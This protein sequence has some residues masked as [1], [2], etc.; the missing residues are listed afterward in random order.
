MGDGTTAANQSDSPTGRG[1]DQPTT[2]APETPATEEFQWTGYQRDQHNTGVNSAHEGFDSLSLEWEYAADSRVIAPVA[3][4]GDVIIGTRTGTVR[5]LDATDGTE[6]WSTT[7]DGHVVG[8]ASLSDTGVLAGTQK[9][10]VY[11]LDRS[12]GEVTWQTQPGGRIWEGLTV[13][14]GTSY[15]GTGNGVFVY[16]LT[17]Q[18]RLWAHEPDERLSAPVRAPVVEEDTIY[19]GIDDTVVAF[20]RATG[21][22]LWSAPFDERTRGAVVLRGD[23]IVANLQSTV[24][25][26]SASTGELQWQ[27]SVTDD[28]L[29]QCSAVGPDRVFTGHKGGFAALDRDS[30]EVQWE[31]E[32]SDTAFTPIVLGDTV[33]TIT[34]TTTLYAL[35]KAGE[36]RY[37]TVV[38]EGYPQPIAATSSRFYAAS[39]TGL[40]AYS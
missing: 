14:D 40:V 37:Q 22:Q 3:A 5:S 36:Q 13:V 9:G 8:P 18:E 30:G 15:V 17:T 19:T 28:Y 10:N 39:G 32:T 20:D 31:I 1:T 16:D 27:R 29:S 6:Q 12:T 24:T 11:L 7:I 26:V 23:Q 25:A 33:Y 2:T 21:D 38:G 35:S 4:G 34:G